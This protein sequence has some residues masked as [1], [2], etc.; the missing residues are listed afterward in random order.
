MPGT[1]APL[2]IWQ[3]LG[4]LTTGAR[5]YARSQSKRPLATQFWTAVFIYAC[6]D[7]S[8]QY[9]GDE[10]YDVKRTGRSIVIGGV[11]ALPTYKWFIW[12]S[13]SFN[14]SSRLLSLGTKIL[15]NQTVFTPIFNSYFFGCQAALSGENLAGTIERIK[16]T[17]PTS[18]VNSAKL[19]P[20]VTAFSFTFV[21]VE[22]RSAC[23]GVVAV[24]WQTYLSLLN[25]QAEMKEHLR[26]ESLEEDNKGNVVS[27]DAQAA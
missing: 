21:P 10:E 12:L 11:A 22:Y 4:P 27:L 14:Y 2:P 6:A 19:W 9:V 13:H 5:A 7:L 17:V 3:R 1:V 16:D 15:V 8:A 23:H 18:I 25:K 20:I 26:H 24:G